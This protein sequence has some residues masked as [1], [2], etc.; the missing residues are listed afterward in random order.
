MTAYLRDILEQASSWP[1]EDQLE[2]AEYAHLIKARRTG[3][4][5][6]TAEERA[7]I[8]EGL[9]QANGGEFAS[10]ED[11]AEFDRSI[12]RGGPLQK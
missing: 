11:V 8:E 4:Y 5:R 2:L 12:R 1:E 10:D 9:A 7:A 3:V 6:V